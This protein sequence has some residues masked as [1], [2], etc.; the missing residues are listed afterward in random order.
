[1]RDTVTIDVRSVW[2]KVQAIP[3]KGTLGVKRQ[4]TNDEEWMLWLSYKRKS[5]KVLGQT[6]HYSEDRLKRE[7]ARLE[8]QGGPKGTRPEWMK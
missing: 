6:M 2:A 1:M 4:L 3:D 8:S 5:V 7:Y